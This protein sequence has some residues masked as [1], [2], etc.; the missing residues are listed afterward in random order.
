MHRPPGRAAHN[1]CVVDTRLHALQIAL[2]LDR[3]SKE[4]QVVSIALLDWAEKE[5]THNLSPEIRSGAVAKTHIEDL[6]AKLLDKAYKLD[7]AEEYGKLI[8]HLF[9]TAGVLY[10]VMLQFGELSEEISQK[11][12]Y[13]KWKTIYIS[14]CLKNGEAPVPGPPGEQ[15]KGWDD[16]DE[17]ELQNFL[18]GQ[19]NHDQ[20]KPESSSAHSSPEEPTSGSTLVPP[21]GGQGSNASLPSSSF[22]AVQDT[23]S[24]TGWLGWHVQVTEVPAGMGSAG[25]NVTTPKGRVPLAEQFDGRCPPGVLPAPSLLSERMDKKGEVRLTPELT[26]KAQKYCKWAESAL[27]YNDEPTAINYLTKALKLVQTGVDE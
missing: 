7:L 25:S 11:R 9:Y 15:G 10:D 27:S 17:M 6:A 1:V 3:K 16:D 21:A 19:D 18:G 23:T 20:E 2:K 8:I 26:V 14:N 22:V 4:A 12:K 24:N 13:A 5:K